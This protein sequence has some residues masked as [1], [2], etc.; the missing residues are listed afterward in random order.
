MPISSDRVYWY[1]GGRASQ[2]GDERFRSWG[3]ADLA[4]AYAH[5]PIEARTLIDCTDEERVLWGDIFHLKPIRRYVRG[6]V[7]LLGDAAH[8]MTPYLGQGAC[9]A[10]EDAVVLGECV[11]AEP[12]IDRAFAAYEGRRRKRAAFLQ[13]AS[14]SQVRLVHVRNPLLRAARDALLRHVPEGLAERRTRQ[15]L[16]VDFEVPEVE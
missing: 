5:F 8:A 3:K 12:E 2:P 14:M 9:Q 11:A 4:S 10:F 7:A 15:M 16:T 6:R 1:C 13:K